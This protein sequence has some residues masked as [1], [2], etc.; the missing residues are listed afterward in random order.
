M[1]AAC[2]SSTLETVDHPTTARGRLNRTSQRAQAGWE[3]E[4][5]P[6]RRSRRRTRQALR[7]PRTRPSLLLW[8][9]RHLVIAVTLACAVVTALSILSPRANGTQEVVVAA[10]AVPAGTILT[11]QDLDVRALPRQALPAD[12]L[13]DAP[14]LG[15]RAAIS[16]EPGQVLT[17]SMAVATLAAGARAGERVIQVPVQAGAGLAEVGSRVD[18]VAH[19]EDSDL[20]QD[21]TRQTGTRSGS[22]PA[23]AQV[24]C[25]GARVL[26]TQTPD[27]TASAFSPQTAGTIVTL[28]TLAVPEQAAPVIVA[29]ATTGALGLVLSP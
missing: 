6:S 13:L 22:P 15:A 3:R 29:V 16:L 2:V 5:R 28:V 24:L 14:P 20:L 9:W 25:T 10:R 11:E 27:A 17:R 23:Q 19:T 4:A 7:R 21:E 8:R 12:G 26:L 1:H 18:V